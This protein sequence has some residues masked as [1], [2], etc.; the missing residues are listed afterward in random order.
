MENRQTYRKKPAV[1]VWRKWANNDWVLFWKGNIFL[2]DCKEAEKQLVL[3]F[4]SSVSLCRA[5]GPRRSGRAGGESGRHLGGGHGRKSAARGGG[6]RCR[7]DAC[8]SSSQDFTMTLY[9]RHY[10]KDERLAFKSNTNLSMTFDGRLVKKIWVPDMFFVHSKKSF[11]HDTTTE[12][13]ML[14]VYP[15]GK[16]LYSLR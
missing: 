8:V 11:T 1:S 7:R 14:R 3:P 15:D 2:C 4:W 16:V 6:V 5:R 10:W 13:V 12:N 9:L